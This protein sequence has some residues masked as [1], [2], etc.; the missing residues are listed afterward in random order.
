MNEGRFPQVGD[1]IFFCLPRHL[2]LLAG[3]SLLGSFHMILGQLVASG[4]LTDPEVSFAS[5]YGLTP[6][7]VHMNFS[8]PR[9]NFERRVYNTR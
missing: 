3:N 1:S 4:Q 5:V 2:P 8:L 6:V 7:T 9:G